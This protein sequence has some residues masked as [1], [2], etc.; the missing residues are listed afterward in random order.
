MIKNHWGKIVAAA[1]GLGLGI[2]LLVKGEIGPG[3]TTILKSLETLGN[4]NGQS[5]QPNK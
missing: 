1:I 2:F 3:T 4:S 5:E